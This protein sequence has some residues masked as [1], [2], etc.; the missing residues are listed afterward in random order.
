MDIKES[1]TMESG[2]QIIE[3]WQVFK[4]YID[5]KNI[6]TVAERFVDVCADFGTSDE[7]FREVLGPDSPLIKQLVIIWKR[8]LMMT[9]MVQAKMMIGTKHGMVF[10]IA[11][12]ISPTPNAID[13]YETELED[14]K[15]E[16]KIMA[17]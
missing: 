15:K 2:S 9:I 13:Y 6:E 1:Q 17:T 12:D 3:I 14:A 16:C 8:I 11:K 4:E 7:S 5:K 10:K